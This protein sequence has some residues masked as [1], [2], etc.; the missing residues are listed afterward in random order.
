MRLAL[1]FGGMVFASLASAEILFEE[2]FSGG[3]P[4][5][6]WE[7]QWGE[8]SNTIEVDFQADNPSGDGFVGKLGNDLS[9]GGVGSL[10]VPAGNDLTDYT[11]HA[12]VYL[13]LGQTHYRGVIGRSTGVNGDDTFTHYSFLAD[14]SENTGMGDQRFRLRVHGLD[15]FPIVI[16][17][18]DAEELGSLYPAEDGWYRMSMRMEGNQIWCYINDQMLPGCPF[19]DNNLSSGSFGVYFWD[20][21]VVDQFLFFDDMVVEGEATSVEDAE[22]PLGFELLS[23]YPNPF[24]PQTW[25]RFRLDSPSR[26]QLAVYNL[27]G[28]KV[29]QLAQGSWPAG[30]HQLPWDG[31]NSLGQEVA[32]GTYLLLLDNGRQSQSESLLLTR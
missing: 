4:D 13:N 21:A 1:L 23:S 6:G 14:L 22:Q 18:W 5:L 12:Q 16:R 25:T 19:T 3:T 26:I 32:S 28:Q 20:F 29:R 8:E 30:L 10:Y 9:G 11:V 17:D 15:Q 27:Q 31:R 2:T 24:N 7:T